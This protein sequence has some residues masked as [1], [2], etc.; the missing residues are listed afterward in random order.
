MQPLK[1]RNFQHLPTFGERV[2]RAQGVDLGPR[3]QRTWHLPGSDGRW[4][5]QDGQQ[6][7]LVQGFSQVGEHVDEA[8]AKNQEIKNRKSRGL[9]QTRYRAGA[10]SWAPS[11]LEVWA[12]EALCTSHT[13][14]PGQ[15]SRPRGGHLPPEAG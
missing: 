15:P 8:P 5:D 14:A 10:P 1:F 6:P 9:T 7:G 11:A 4:D 13:R 3:P 12:P 2:V